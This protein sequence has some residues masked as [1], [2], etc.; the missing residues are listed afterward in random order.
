MRTGDLG[1]FYGGQLYVTGRLKEMVVIHGSNFYPHDIEDAVRRCHD[2]I[3]PG[4]VVAFATS[5]SDGEGLAVLVELKESEEP[6]PAGRTG[7]LGKKDIARAQ[8]LFKHAQKL[9]SVVRGPAIRGLAKLGAWWT[10]GGPEGKDDA[11]A[12]ETRAAYEDG[13]MEGV[14]KAIRRA[15]LTHFGIPVID[16]ILAQAVRTHRRTTTRCAPSVARADAVLRFPVAV[17]RGRC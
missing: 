1:A 7:K 15:V 4:S 16:V 3:R 12:V 9:P 8:K 11:A 6:S 2:A 5:G 17:C 10:S 14:E 13:E